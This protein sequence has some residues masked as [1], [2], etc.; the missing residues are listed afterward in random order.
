MGGYKARVYYDLEGIPHTWVQLSAPDGAKE[1]KG[2]NG[3]RLPARSVLPFPG[4]VKSIILFAGG[5]Q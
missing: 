1:S 3:K 2:G 5:R 4:D